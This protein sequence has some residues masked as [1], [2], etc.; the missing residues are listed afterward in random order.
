MLKGFR[1]IQG[2]GTEYVIISLSR[3]FLNSPGNLFAICSFTEAHE[4]KTNDNVSVIPDCRLDL[5]HTIIVGWPLVCLEM[6]SELVRSHLKCDVVESTTMSQ[7]PNEENK[8]RKTSFQS[9][10]FLMGSSTKPYAQGKYT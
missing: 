10:Q 8:G 1:N 7:L 3:F 9:E 2:D 4:N 6:V 5:A